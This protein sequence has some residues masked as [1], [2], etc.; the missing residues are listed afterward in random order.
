MVITIA[1][2]E[3]HGLSLPIKVHI[4]G[5]LTKLSHMGKIKNIVV[6]YPTPYEEAVLKSEHNRRVTK[7]TKVLSHKK[8]FRFVKLSQSGSRLWSNGARNEMK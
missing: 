7:I 4:E 8:A 6:G 1:Q 3:L 2:I 5:F